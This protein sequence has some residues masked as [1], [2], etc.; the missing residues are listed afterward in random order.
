MAS[1]YRST[2]DQLTSDSFDG[3]ATASDN[4]PALTWRPRPSA[5]TG[6]SDQADCYAPPSSYHTRQDAAPCLSADTGVSAQAD[7]YALPSSYHAHQD[8][9]RPLAGAI[10]I[11]QVTLPPDT[12]EVSSGIWR[13]DQLVT[14]PDTRNPDDTLTS[15][16]SPDLRD[17]RTSLYREKGYRNK[18]LC[19]AGT[20]RRVPIFE[21]KDGEGTD[22]W[23]L[24][25]GE[26]SGKVNNSLTEQQASDI[27][28]F[29]CS[30][31]CA[32]DVL[33]E[34]RASDG[35]RTPH[36]TIYGQY[37]GDLVYWD[38]STYDM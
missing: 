34:F 11:N 3:S 29:A 35:A 17:L 1:A 9:A 19:E 31:A 20:D 33:S 6:I 25:C 8:A 12:R 18:I 15:Y 16:T 2:D 22:F 32:E 38:M 28:L 21:E 14:R 13:N 10:T 27:E 5:D 30:R 24:N 4:Q 23:C 37:G 26:S 7:C 36:S